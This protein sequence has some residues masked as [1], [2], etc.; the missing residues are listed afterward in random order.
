M[1][2]PAE[3]PTSATG[4][5]QKPH[6]CLRAFILCRLGDGWLWLRGC[7]RQQG[8][9]R[10]PTCYARRHLGVPWQVLRMLWGPWQDQGPDAWTDDILFIYERYDELRKMPC[11]Q[12]MQPI[13]K[14]SSNMCHESIIHRPMRLIGAPWTVT[15]SSIHHHSSDPET[16]SPNAESKE[17][18]HMVWLQFIRNCL[19]ICMWWSS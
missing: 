16:S 5:W 13:F 3:A 9:G 11:M 19:A 4:W 1:L 15:N 18:A 17:V 10:G 14:S 7:K 2:R 12:S 6:N 8:F